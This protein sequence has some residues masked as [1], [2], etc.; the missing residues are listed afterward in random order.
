[1]RSRPRVA[2]LIA[3]LALT[4]SGC[5]SDNS[6]RSAANRYVDQVN[7]AQREF[8]NTVQ[9]L[10]TATSPT[11]PASERRRALGRFEGAVATIVAR[12]RAIRPPR[13]VAGQH[14][15]LI[16][17]IAGF[18][19][20]VKTAGTALSSRDAVQLRRA[21]ALLLSEATRAGA[22][23]SATIDAINRRLRG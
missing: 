9:G 6:A 14:A 20:A 23:I 17:E 10:S 1:M 13:S 8:A 5:G 19:V 11:S 21:S 3:V 7:Q 22:M 12:F 2:A 16:S 15:Q 4:G 18:G